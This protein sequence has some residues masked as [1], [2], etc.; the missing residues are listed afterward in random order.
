MLYSEL[1]RALLLLL[2]AALL[3][4]LFVHRDY[5]QRLWAGAL[6]ACVWQFQLRLLAFALA[7]RLGLFGFAP[8][9]PALYGVPF[10]MLLGLSLLSG[11]LVVIRLPRTPTLLWV[12]PDFALT[13]FLLP[14]QLNDPLAAPWLLAVSHFAVLPGLALGRWTAAD[15][16]LYA[17]AALQA[18]GWAVLLLWLFPSLVFASSGDS[19]AALLD[20]PWQLNTLYAAPL[21]I[22]ALLLASALYEFAVRGG[23]TAFPYDPPRRL[24]TSGAYRFVSNPMQLGI[25]L[26]MA[27]WGLLLQSLWIS[28][29]ALVAIALFTAFGGVCNG[30]CQIGAVDPNWQRYQQRVR[31]WLPLWRPIDPRDFEEVP[32]DS[33]KTV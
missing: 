23:G 7:V 20:R 17:R 22:P 21:L 3:A 28:C 12:L 18:L 27:G 29:S 2:P 16:R 6:L 31:K 30:S 4:W 5:S 33:A 14:V 11:P 19:W 8:S 24:V 32:H 26:L 15:T 25:V 1:S 9:A 10:D 13:L